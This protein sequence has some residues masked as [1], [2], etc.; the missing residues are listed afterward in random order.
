MGGRG[1]GNIEDRVSKS[2]NKMSISLAD[3][4]AARERLRGSIYYSPCAHSQMLSAQIGQQIYLKLENLQMT[5]SFKERG[6][7]N[8]ITTLTPEQATRGVVAASAGNHAQG[9]AYH[10]TKRGIRALIV[11]PLA[12][13][14]VKVTAT[15]GFGAEVVLH[16]ANYDEACDEALRICTAEE[17][18]FI[19]PFDDPLVMA[20]QGTIGLELL[21]QVPELQAVAVPIGGGGLIGG[22]ACAIKESRPDIR[23]I[24]VQTSR[25][26]SMAAAIEQHGPVTLESATT[27][28]DGIAVRRAGDVTFP[29][30]EKYVDEIVTV[31]E[32]EIASAI[33]V[34]LEREKTLAEG[35]GAA[36]LAALIQKK[37]TLTNERTAVIVSAGNI[38]VTLLSRIIE[39]GLVQDGRMIRLR[40]HL[41][42]KPGA[43]SELTKLIASH[44]V[45][46][47]DTLYNRAYYGVN[48]G[49]TAIDITLETRGR[50][51]V[52]ELLAALTAE[53]YI[54][55]R[56]I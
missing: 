54:H 21:E 9:V 4:Q 5:G 31:D 53:G 35:A 33:L 19:H 27:I 42:D 55:S 52:A 8:R 36:A 32:D 24:G 40:I 51:Q 2:I 43:L 22:I 12:T 1:S 17:M 14:L 48:L 38:D 23:V 50:E 20:G 47:V 34:L 41:L 10:A 7:L 29:V 3:V 13:P 28:A 45:N 44:R 46:I 16:G 6:A 11:M 56:V 18:T 25:L 15:R 30:V 26:P 49:N 37:T 39:R